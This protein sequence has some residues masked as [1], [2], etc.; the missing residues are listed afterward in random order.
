LKVVLGAPSFG[1]KTVRCFLSVCSLLWKCSSI[2]V[3]MERT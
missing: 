3:F 2:T 1:V